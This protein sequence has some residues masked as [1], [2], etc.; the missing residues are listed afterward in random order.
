[1]DRKDLAGFLRSSRL[2]LRLRPESVGLPA[3]SSRHHVESGY[4]HSKTMQHPLVG[5]L[6]LSCD[7]LAVPIYDQY[8]VCMTAERNSPSEE[9]LRLLSVVGTQDMTHSADKL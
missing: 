2:R 5:T 6:Q 4:H 7:M 3:G 1:M 9:A 8:L